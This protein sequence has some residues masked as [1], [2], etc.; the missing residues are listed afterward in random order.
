MTDRIAR[1]FSLAA[2]CVAM[3]LGLVSCGGGGGGG[4]TP[5]EMTITQPLPDHSDT[6]ADAAPIVD[7]Q[8]ITGEIDSADDVD[9]FRLQISEPSRVG[10]L[11][12]AEAGLQIELLDSQGNVLDVAETQSPVIVAFAAIR[13]GVFLVRVAPAAIRAV[14]AAAPFVKKTFRLVAKVQAARSLAEVV[15]ES[16]I[17]GNPTLVL[18]IG[19]GSQL[20]ASLNFGDYYRGRRGDGSTVPL[21]FS[22]DANSGI[23]LAEAGFTVNITGSNL[24]AAGDPEKVEPGTYMGRA[25]VFLPSTEQTIGIG[26]EQAAAAVSQII[27]FVVRVTRADPEPSP[28]SRP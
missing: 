27:T 28:P 23:I 7:G 16:L 13:A 19:E 6:M 14:R 12:D 2:L 22:I 26:A 11:L 9:Y 17:E 4:K 1:T 25:K 8:T 5:G 3:S 21:A 18:R 15:I 24:N 10:F 20:R